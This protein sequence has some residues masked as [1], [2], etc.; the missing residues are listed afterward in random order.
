M[1][2]VA[3]YLQQ[4]LGGEILTAADVLDYFAFDE[5]IFTIRPQL[6]VYPRSEND[7][8]KVCRFTWQLAEKG[9]VVPVTARGMGT[10]QTGAA[11]GS[12]IVIAT[13]AHLNKV[14][15]FDSK[16]GVI[17]AEAGT[18]LDKLQQVLHTHGR[19]LP[20]ISAVN[21]YA[22]LG[23]AVSNNDRGRASYKYGPVSEFVRGLR[24]V[25]ANGELI[26][27][28]RLSKREFNKKLGLASFE[29]EIYRSL[30][31]LIEESQGYLSGMAAVTDISPAGYGLADVKQ[32]D[33]SVDLT[34][35]FVGSQGTLGIITEITLN[36][37]PYNPQMTQVVAGFGERL[38]GWQAIHEINKLKEGP[39]SIDFIDSSLVGMIQRI[40][41]GILKPLGGGMPAVLF[42][43][44]IDGDN[45]RARKRLQKK[46]TK[47]LES[48]A[49]EV[50]V[51]K[52]EEIDEWERLRDS[53]SL[54]LTHDSGKKRAIPILDDAYVP[55]DRMAEFF[56]EFEELMKVAGFTEYAAWG[57]AGSGLVHVAPL[58]DIASVGDRQ[59]MFKVMDAYYDYVCKIGGSIA[60]EYAEGRV[61][62][63]FND[64]LFQPEAMEAFRKLKLI[65]DPTRTLNPDVKIN[66]RTNELRSHVRDT[67]VLGYQYSHL[68]RS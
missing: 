65:F 48:Q 3:H 62:G 49:A 51:P 30:D 50:V 22:T 52:P 4:H 29:G 61:R 11:L 28:G 27:T 34:P 32:K 45:V 68:P 66:V 13:P 47:I 16:S 14:V 58:L 18:T 20:A 12:G 44:D 64:K 2:K 24:V 26:E 25:L 31:K 6:V 46:I 42:F 63:Q 36:T 35:L 55:I 53:A 21:K 39:A 54:H 57:Q 17:T 37:A 56:T 67:Y 8:R 40:N 10:D 15:E 59:K 43:I 5:S 9:K 33:G 7:I 19:F 60:G 41:P 38:N 1:N 23:G